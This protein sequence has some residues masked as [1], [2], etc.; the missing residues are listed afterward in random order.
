MAL[1][2]GIA[3]LLLLVLAGR[4]IVKTNPAA[5][6]KLGR[7]AGGVAL[8]GVG[9]WLT[10]TGRWEA[11]LP[12]GAFGLSLLGYGSHL[13]TI[14]GRRNPFGNLGGPAG[15]LGGGIPPGGGG[16]ALSTV[17]TDMLAMQLDHRTGQISGRVRSGPYGGQAL[18][19]LSLS[20][21]ALLW[22]SLAR[23]GESRALLETYLDRRQP[24]WRQDFHDDPAARQRGAA[25]AGGMSIEE[26]YET[27]G[28]QPGATETEIRTAHRTLMKRVHPDVGGTAA[29]A[30][31]LNQAKDRL[32]G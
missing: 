31:R 30:A 28:L 27:L 26:A 5:L 32:L 21:L 9:L 10:L 13:Q 11:G 24:G 18:Q 3:V 17:E 23:D 8:I 12:V 7:Q 22:R 25:T 16:P 2:L 4:G 15:G 19:S 1:I 14:L 6:A 29:L 20:E